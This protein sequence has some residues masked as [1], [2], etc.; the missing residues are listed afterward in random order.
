MR[1]DVKGKMEVWEKTGGPRGNNYHEGIHEVQREG[2]I[3]LTSED[4]KNSTM[5]LSFVSTERGDS[6]NYPFVYFRRLSLIFSDV[7]MAKK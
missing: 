7:V 3:A 4:E 6:E 5:L 2:I 1:V